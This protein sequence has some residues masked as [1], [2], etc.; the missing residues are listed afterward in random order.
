MKIFKNLF[1]KN[2]K[3]EIEGRQTHN[4]YLNQFSEIGKLVKEAR[5]KKNISVNEL[6]KISKILLKLLS[7]VDIVSR[8]STP[9]L[10]ALF[11]VSSKEDDIGS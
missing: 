11:I 1:L 8:N 6:S 4:Y 9:S 10:L 7:S 2:K 3:I 5:I